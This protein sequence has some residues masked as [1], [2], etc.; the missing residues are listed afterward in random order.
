M[1]NLVPLKNIHLL[2]K[3]I[4]LSRKYYPKQRKVVV[5]G[6]KR[7]REI[8]IKENMSLKDYLNYHDKD[9]NLLVCLYLQDGGIIAYEVSIIK[10]T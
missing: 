1:E 8:I 4:D 5:E 6:Y 9:P 3:D 2:T 7:S 10:F